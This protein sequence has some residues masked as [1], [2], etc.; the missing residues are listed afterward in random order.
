MDR[1]RAHLAR[2]EI[3]EYLKRGKIDEGELLTFVQSTPREVWTPA[4]P[5]EKAKSGIN[6]DLFP[7]DEFF[8]NN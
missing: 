3:S 4:R 2:P 8:L 6:T 1:M 7:R 5:P